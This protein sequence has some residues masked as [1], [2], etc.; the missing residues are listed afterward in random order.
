MALQPDRAYLEIQAGLARTQLEHLPM[1]ARSSWSWTEGYGLLAADPQAV[2][3]SWDMARA[4]AAEA[5]D[6]LLPASALAEAH[7]LAAGF[8]APEEALATGSGWAALEIEAG[9]LPASLLLPFGAPDAEQQPW[10]ELLATGALPISDPPAAPVTGRHWRELLEVNAEDWHAR[11][12]L[13]LLRLADGED[14]AAR[15]A[16]KCSLEQQAT[17]WVLRALAFLTEAPGDAADLLVR[18]HALRPGLREL[19]IEALDALLRADRPAE[20]LRIIAALSGADRE[21]GRIRLAEAKAAL[22]TGATDRVRELLAEGIRVDNMREGEV[23]LHAL[24]LAVHPGQPVPPA[25][26]FRMSEG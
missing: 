5:L 7:A 8:G 15:D 12:Q 9:S 3:G 26:D 19:T 25:Y 20:A 23:S 24:W 10:R 18:A 13:G 11:Y 17:P 22:A 21:H 1:P 14:E 4:A 2:H 16:W 6:R